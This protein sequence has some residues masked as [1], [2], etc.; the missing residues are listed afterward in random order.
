MRDVIKW[1]NGA[2]TIQS[3]GKK[4]YEWKKL[5][6]FS[7]I[8]Q[9]LSIA[10]S[11]PRDIS[12]ALECRVIHINSSAGLFI[13]HY[14]NSFVYFPEFSNFISARFFVLFSL[15]FHPPNVCF[16]TTFFVYYLCQEIPHLLKWFFSDRRMNIN[17]VAVGLFRNYNFVGPCD[18]ATN[19]LMKIN[20]CKIVS[21]LQR[22][23]TSSI[24]ICNA[25][26]VWMYWYI[27]DSDG[28]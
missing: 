27:R 19:R 22:S 21:P 10:A 26:F 8:T 1:S 23:K 5:S 2:L 9:A 4:T 14:L 24:F 12:L 13:L 6:N 15:L 3:T 18:N 7:S 28:V 25:W 11:F 20:L 16:S 17:D